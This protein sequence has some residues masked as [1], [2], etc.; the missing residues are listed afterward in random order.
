MAGQHHRCND[1]NLGKLRET[2]RPGVLRSTGLQ[3]VRHDCVT[4]QQQWLDSDRNFALFIF[5]EIRNHRW[6]DL[7]VASIAV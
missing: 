6:A 2:V 5:K 4:E 1:M 3:R 7:S